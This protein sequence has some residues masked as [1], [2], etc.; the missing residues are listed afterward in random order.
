[1]NKSIPLVLSA[2]ILVSGV[3]S[4]IRYD[5]KGYYYGSDCIVCDSSIPFGLKPGFSAGYP[6][7]FTLPDRQGFELVGSGFQCERTNFKI[8]TISQ[9]GYTRNALIVK[10]TD[11]ANY[12]RYLISYETGHTDKPGNQTI[13]FENISADSPERILTKYQWYKLDE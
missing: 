7:T 5:N 11:S 10:C 1:M 2:V 13:S 9:Y 6:Q 4:F 3:A 8:N 12:D